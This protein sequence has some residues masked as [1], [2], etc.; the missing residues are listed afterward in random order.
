MGSMSAHL[1]ER[2]PTGIARRAKRKLSMRERR[3]IVE[4][5]VLLSPQLILFLTL[6]VVPFFVGIPIVLTDRSNFTD[7]EVNYVGMENFTRIWADPSIARDYFPAVTRT[8]RF[9][10]LNYVMVYL[11]GLTLALLMYEVGFRGRFFTIVYLPRML[12]GLAVGFIA[13]MLFAESTGSMNLL[14][15]KLGW[16][17]EPINIKLERGTTIALPILMGWRHAGYNMALFLTGLLSISRET[18]EA[19]IVDG[20]TYWQ[21]L[22]RVYFPQMI[23]SFIIA[24]VFCVTGSFQVFDMLVALGGM[25]GNKAAEF[26]SIVFFLHAFQRNRMAL[27]LAMS[28][29]TFLPLAVIGVSLQ[30]LQRRL[31]YDV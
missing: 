15:L 30:R 16:I 18:I 25:V 24:T 2:A 6:T 20:A 26:V 21:R 28:L 17:R 23:P 5:L 8:A 10:L 1:P 13:V 3:R 12:S 4:D 9:T 7:P 14:L 19:A 22:T 27:G 29:E 11:F 31:A